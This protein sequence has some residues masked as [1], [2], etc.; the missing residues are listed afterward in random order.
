MIDT[1]CHLTYRG[2]AERVDEVLEG[3]REAGVDRM[4]SIGTG[5]ADSEK[6]AVLAGEREGVYATVGLH[7]HH[8]GELVDESSFS[9]SVWRLAG[10]PGVVGLGEMGLDDHYDDPPGV[11]QERAFAVQLGLAGEAGLAHLPVV[12]HNRE[13][14]E[15]TV[16]MVRESGLDVGRF[17]FH[18]FTGTA[19]ELDVILDLGVWVGLT[20]IVTF[21]SARDVAEA[22]DRIPI[23]RLLVETDAPYLTPAPHRKVRPNEP[24]YVVEVARFLAERRGMSYEALVERVD[25]NAERFYGLDAVAS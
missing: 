1:H 10:L 13:A 7:P 20:G 11:V 17:V 8:A 2:L 3:A 22:S 14:T 15:R 19:D 16:G 25:R 9:Q 4:V 21:N 12:V 6:A 18:C 23:D 5:I 24:K